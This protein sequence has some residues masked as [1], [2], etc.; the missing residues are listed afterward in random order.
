[1][2]YTLIDQIFI[3][4]SPNQASK[5]FIDP[6]SRYI[7][8]NNVSDD[9]WPDYVISMNKDELK[10]DLKSFGVDIPERHFYNVEDILRFIVT[11][12]F[13]TYSDK[14]LLE[15]FFVSQVIAPLNEFILMI[16]KSIKDLKNKE[17]V[18]KSLND[19]F[20]IDISPEDKTLIEELKF[21]CNQLIPI[22]LED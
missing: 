6:R 12:N 20:L 4:I 11:Y 13:Q 9:V 10:G 19:F 17:D 8:K 15:E 18:F 3:R 5:N 7:G 16:R 14:I 2:L 22:W 1:M 21:A